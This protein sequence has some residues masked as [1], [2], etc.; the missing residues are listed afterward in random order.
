[1]VFGDRAAL[2]R[3]EGIIHPRVREQIVAR[4]KEVKDKTLAALDV[5]LLFEAGMEG[6]TDRTVVVTI[7]ENQRFLRLRR[8]GFSEREIIG[9]LGV[10]MAQARK[11]ALADEIIDN[12]GTLETTRE[13]TQ[14]L[15][16]KLL[17]ETVKE[18]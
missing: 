17:G 2:R 13:Q 1:M 4:L 9:R 3:L 16:N 12:S 10:Q 14:T 15:L 8:R 5:P 6:M 18:S 11:K 7:A